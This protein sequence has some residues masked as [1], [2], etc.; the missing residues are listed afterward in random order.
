VRLAGRRIWRETVVLDEAAERRVEIVSRPNAVLVGV[1]AWPRDL[2]EFGERFS[3]VT[4]VVAPARADLSA[5]AGWARVVLPEDT[6][7]ALAVVPAERSGAADRWYLYS[8]V[9]RRVTRLD[10]AP[11]ALPL[12]RWSR[13]LWGFTIVDSEVGGAAMV[14]DVRA[15]GPAAAAGLKPGDRILGVGGR[16]VS[17]GA[18][19]RQTLA[20][21]SPERPI[22]MSWRTVAGET[23]SGELQ[24]ASSPLLRTGEED[25]PTAMLRAAWAVLDALAAP[26]E[27]SAALSNLALI[28][29]SLGQHE[30]AVD[31]WRRVR[32]TQRAGIGDGTRSYYLGRELE[33]LGRED[34][35]V[36]AYRAAAASEATVHD[37]AGPRVAPA[38]RDRLADLGVSVSAP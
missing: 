15:G 30:V 32:W 19:I 38:A 1:D 18:E 35:A 28:F 33:S 27:T 5:V 31:T 10:A 21:A 11:P 17:G 36:E 37:D 34:E 8:P 23:L 22:E 24:G 25:L 4:G 14:V 7:L 6:D 12:P 3:T 29:G 2:A 9:L 16:E 20:A 26:E 13:T